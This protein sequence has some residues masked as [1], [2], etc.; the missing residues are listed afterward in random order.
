L[1]ASL[2]VKKD[3]TV[4]DD[5]FGLRVLAFL[6]ENE[7]INEA[8]KVILQL[9]GLVGTVDDPTIV[10]GVGIGLGSEF[11]AEVFDYIVARTRQ[12]LRDTA[13]IDND[14]LDTVSLA[15]NLGLEFLHLVTIEGVLHIAANVDGSHGCGLLGNNLNFL[16]DGSGLGTAS[17]VMRRMMRHMTCRRGRWERAE[18]HRRR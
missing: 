6:A 13:K 7:L 3:M 18:E 11:E 2:A 8:I 4:L 1:T 9:R 17:T 12:R 10:G 5:Y 15:F 14:C 16:L